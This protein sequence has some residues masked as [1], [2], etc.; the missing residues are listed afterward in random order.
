MTRLPL[1]LWTIVYVATIVAANVLTARY[2]LVPAGFGLHVAAGT[3]A[4]GFALFARDLLH[5]SAAATL[6]PRRGV[7]Y[8]LGAIL[9]AGLLSWVTSTPNLAVA[10][11]VAFVGA[12]LVDLVVF[13]RVRRRA[14][15]AAA[16][17]ASNVVAAPVDTVAFLALAGF[18]ITATVVGG[19]LLAKLAYATLIP[20][21]VAVVLERRRHPS[22]AVAA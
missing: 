1:T 16:I 3:Y 7:A 19:Q 12:E 5:R 13:T 18:P 4:A 10:S 11:T 17:L 21:A 20:L 14:G 15:L 6:G 22:R 8:V 9:V 2:Q